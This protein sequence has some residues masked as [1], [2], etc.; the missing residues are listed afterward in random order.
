MPSPTRVSD[1]SAPEVD[2]VNLTPPQY[3]AHAIK[4]DPRY[5]KAYY[6]YDPAV[7]TISMLDLTSLPGAVARR[8]I[9]KF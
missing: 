2:I 4:L 3:T 5:A 6:R 7:H 8:V 1:M 9:C